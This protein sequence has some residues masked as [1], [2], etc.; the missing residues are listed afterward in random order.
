LSIIWNSIIGAVVLA[1]FVD[2]KTN[3]TRV[4]I[5]VLRDIGNEVGAI[6]A[7]ALVAHTWKDRVPAQVGVVNV[8]VTP[9]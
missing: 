7:I 3:I 8:V 6:P 9:V 1:P 5:V 2:A 4:E